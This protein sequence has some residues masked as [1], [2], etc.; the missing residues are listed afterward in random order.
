MKTTIAGFRLASRPIGLAKSLIASA[1]FLAALRGQAHHS[2]ELGIQLVATNQ[3]QLFWQPVTGFEQVQQANSLGQTNLWQT[4]TNAPSLQSSLLLLLQNSTNA[5]T[6]YRLTNGSQ[7]I[8]APTNLTDPST[9]V[10]PPPPN[11]QLSFA[12]S[13]SFLYSGSNAVQFGASPS[14]IAPAQAAVLRGR[15][16][17]RSGS[18]LAGV[19]VWIPSQPAYGYTYSRANGAYDLAVNGGGLVT[20]DFQLAGYSPAQRQLPT[21]RQGFAHVP[22]V[23][24]APLDPVATA[25]MLGSNSPTQWATSSTQTDGNGSRSAQVYVP[26][27]TSAEL[28]FANG[29]TQAVSE[30]TF[31]VTELTVGTNGPSTMPAILPPSSA[32]TYC[33]DYTADEALAAGA[34][35][36]NFSQPLY[37]YVTNFLGFPV[38][39]MVPAGYYDR[40][41]SCWVAASNGVIMQMLG[42]TNGLAE[43]SLTTNGLLADAATLA[44]NQFTTNELMELAAEFPPGATLT[45]VPLAHFT[46]WDFN[47]APSINTNAPN[48][49]FPGDVPN[50]PNSGDLNYGTLRTARQVFEETIPLV[51]APCSLNYSSARVPDYRAAGQFNFP[52]ILPPAW[53]LSDGP[54]PRYN[55]VGAEVDATLAGITTTVTNLVDLATISIQ[56]V[57]VAWDGRWAYGTN[58]PSSSTVAQIQVTFEYNTLAWEAF[59]AEEIWWQ[60][61]AV[62][63]NPLF[64]QYGSLSS[65]A[66][67]S[68]ENLFG[69]IVKFTHTLSLPDHRVVG[70]G[71]WSLTQQHYYDPIGQILYLGDGSIRTSPPLADALSVAQDYLTIPVLSVAPL[72]DGS[73]YVLLGTG[74]FLP[75]QILHW[76][77]NQPAIAVSASTGAPA[78]DP[79]GGLVGSQQANGYPASNAIMSPYI[80]EIATGPDDTLYFTCVPGGGNGVIWHIDQ[81]GLLRPV[82]QGGPYQTFRPDG[83]YATNASMMYGSPHLAVGPDGTVFYAENVNTIQTTNS[84]WNGRNWGLIRRVGTDGRIYTVA[85]QGGPS[86]QLFSGAFPGDGTTADLGIGGPASASQLQLPSALC[87]G[88][89]GS[90]YWIHGAGSI[91]PFILR[92]TPSGLLTAALVGFPVCWDGIPGYDTALNCDGELAASLPEINLNN[93]RVGSGLSE[94]PDGSLYFSSLI[95]FGQ[96]GANLLWQLTPDGH[97][98]R[99]AGIFNGSWAGLGRD[100]GLGDNTAPAPARVG[101]DGTLYVAA[102]RNPADGGTQGNNSGYQHTWQLLRMST[103]SPTFATGDISIASD[104]GAELYVFDQNG[105]HLRTINTLTGTTTWLFSYDAN[106]LL[107]SAEDAN[108]LVTTIQRD[109]TGR[110]QAIVGPYGQTT[111]LALDANGFL[112]RATDPAGNVTQLS[113]ST[114]GLL[115]SITGPRGFTY[116]ATYDALGRCLGATDPSGGRDQLGLQQITSF[117]YADESA[118]TYWDSSDTNAAGAVWSSSSILLGNNTTQTQTT[119]PLGITSWE[120]DAVTGN[121]TLTNADGSV[122]VET[123]VGD[124]R[125]PSQTHLLASAT[126]N[127]PGGLAWQETAS[128]N[129]STNSQTTLGAG[130]WTNTYTINSSTYFDVYTGS[131][132]LR[133]TT[134]P[135]GRHVTRQLDAQGRSILVQRPSLADVSMS[136]NSEGNLAFMTE[137]IAGSPES[138]LWGYDVLGRLALTTDPLGLTNAFSYDLA[139]NLQRLTLADGRQI[140]FQSDAE[141]NLT[142]ITPPGRPAHQYGYNAVGMI[143]NY[144]PPE[145]NG[146]NCTVTYSYTTQRQLGQERL[147]DGQNITLNW[148]PDGNITS[149]TLGLGP[150]LSFSNSPESGQL[151][152]ISS[153]TGDS[154]SFTHQGSWITGT[155]LTGLINGQNVVQLNPDLLPA[156]QTIDGTNA[157]NFSYDSDLLLTNIGPLEISRDINGF[158]VGTVLSNLQEQREYD[159]L[160]RLTNCVFTESGTNLW[161]L[162]FAYDAIGRIT[163]K[164][165]S[166]SGVSRVLSYVYDLAGRL[167]QASVNGSATAAYTYDSNGNRLTRNT[168]TYT[169]DAQDRITSYDGEDFGWSPNGWLTAGQGTNYAYDARGALVSV[170]TSGSSI[171]YALDPMGRRSA[172]KFGGSIQR[173]WLWD[174]LLPIAEVD[175][176]SIVTELFIYGADTTTPSVLI[177]GAKTYRILSDERG[178][179]RFVINATDG[180]IAQQLDY[181]EFGRV[182]TDTSPGF[183]PFGFAGGLYDPDVGLV[184]FGERDYSP[185]LG[186]WLQRDPI[187]I[188]GGDMAMYNYVNNDPI[189]ETDP[190]GC[191]PNSKLSQLAAN[192]NP[193][194][195]QAYMNILRANQNIASGEKA[196]AEQ[197]ILAYNRAIRFS[198]GSI[199]VLGVLGGGSAVASGVTALQAG[200][201]LAS[202]AQGTF[203]IVNGLVAVGGNAANVAMN[204]LSNATGAAP[205]F[206]APT[207]LAQGFLPSNVAAVV[208]LAAGRIS[209]PAAGPTWLQT[210][211]KVSGYA[212]NVNNINTL[213]GNQ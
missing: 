110:P 10:P 129:I 150:T 196:G 128:Y 64:G 120:D 145:V 68:G 178:S 4:I 183:Q 92:V 44:T 47:F 161:A 61:G 6:F 62:G 43:I 194:A 27:G 30:L 15:V 54:P 93:I 119:S 25:I 50:Q 195:R 210:A 167:S 2:A 102:A 109:G 5:Q 24:L 165:E 26:P 211:G 154:L 20:V 127:L 160:G 37:T 106:N 164:V 181:D 97:V 135:E 23:N 132:Q 166:F 35:T 90:I 179:V 191:G 175:S 1:V 201:T 49:A 212:D 59:L 176:N 169:Y 33:A 14:A 60:T 42:V 13:T 107:T 8:A 19:H 63:R 95:G 96:G 203:F 79:F 124:P 88:R 139:G 22:D 162:A 65:Q 84:A 209:A 174:G 104:D 32:Y 40:V 207:S 155:A 200:V 71:G 16:L 66:V 177:S 91:T 188:A 18:P 114:G 185:E 149:S 112:A 108:G 12:A 170:S 121:V 28:T 140:A 148:D 103:R 46:A 80:Q 17:T 205:T 202:G 117:T 52:V 115:Q 75:P 180:T 41:R 173:G 45:R 113:N 70:L 157:I 38:G 172:K 58:L 99:A 21:S 184:H 156:V 151:A 152:A 77:P 118:V 146:E 100:V 111:T 56:N 78:M 189:N 130:D 143:T 190:T 126:L 123:F 9:V 204:G 137:Q 31:R 73:C 199:A 57:N 101:P 198:N 86:P 125:F 53:N 144:T 116:A 51:G 147:P 36:V 158:I 193:R 142:S 7:P 153:S 192:G 69:E 138:Y 105:H 48:Q 72:F 34:Q 83:T 89:D 85:G 11:T 206:T 133:V 87:A 98:Q 159:N 67:H 39:A 55:L 3:V 94:G 81:Q 213:S 182:L 74:N 208:D 136:Y 122:L 168:E 141:G 76:Y 131:N 186:R 134:S 29:S 197:S 171:T 163:N 187:N 82:L